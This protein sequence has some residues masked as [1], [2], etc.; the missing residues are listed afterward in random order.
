MKLLEPTRL[1]AAYDTRKDAV[2]LTGGL[3]MYKIKVKR[4][5]A[6]AIEF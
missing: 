2:C 3:Y 4:S 6:E 5:P 1:V